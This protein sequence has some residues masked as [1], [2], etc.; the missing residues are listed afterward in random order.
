MAEREEGALTAVEIA[1]AAAAEA[2]VAEWEEGRAVLPLDP[3]APSAE[4]RRILSALRPTTLAATLPT[5]Q[6]MFPP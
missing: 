6:A 4:R 2:I 5:L 1:G 3:R